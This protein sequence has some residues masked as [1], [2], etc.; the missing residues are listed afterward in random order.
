MLITQ[1]MM[2]LTGIPQDGPRKYDNFKDWLNDQNISES[3]KYKLLWMVAHFETLNGF[4]KKDLQDMLCWICEEVLEVAH[5]AAPML[6]VIDG[7]KNDEMDT[8][9]RGGDQGQNPSA[10]D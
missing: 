2:D 5:S 8:E 10:E 7:G 9:N 6:R 4:T 3:K 1:E